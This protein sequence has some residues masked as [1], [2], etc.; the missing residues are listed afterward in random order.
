MKTYRILTIVILPA[1]LLAACNGLVPAD[2]PL[3]AASLS[4]L[5][6][7]VEIKN[8]GQAA[9]VAASDG[10]VLQIQGQVRTGEDGRA[11]LDLS[12]GTII[13]VAPQTLF[14]LESNDESGGS[15]FTR[16][17]MEA[18]RIWVSLHGGSLEVETPSGL[19]SVRGSYLSVWVDPLTN[20]VWVTCLEG[21]CQAENPAAALD[22]I[23]GEGA[24]LYEF[25]LDSNVPPPPPELRYLTQEEIDEF[26]ANNPEAQQVMGAV[27]ATAS[28][29]PFLPSRTPKPTATDK[30][31]EPTKT[32]SP[33]ATPP[34]E[35]FHLLSPLDGASLPVTGELLLQWEA[36]PGAYKYE[37][38]ITA[39]NSQV[40][41]I[42]KI[43]ETS[44]LIYLGS[45]TM[46]GMYSWQVTAL[47]VN[48]LPLCMAGPFTFSKPALL[49]TATATPKPSATPKPTS[50]GAS[51]SEPTF[52]NING[53]TGSSITTCTNHFQADVTDP[54]GIQYVK[55]QY[56]AFDGG[57]NPV[58]N[59]SYQHLS[60]TG[61]ITYAGDLTITMNPNWH[62]AWWFWVIDAKG[63]SAYYPT[64]P[65]YE[66]TYVGGS[67]CY[68]VP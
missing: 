35:C 11:R 45:L 28:A 57:G 19:A 47:D 39:P 62:I 52:A 67:N 31:D 27:I 29:L 24:I 6:G 36:Q 38:A 40:S 2:G 33:T 32:P 48:R 30:P 44:H 18:G 58:Y 1:L 4:E 34:A 51:N 43:G 66:F 23:A 68:G 63:K 8:P 3:W 46:G 49:L 54:D 22:M 65:L 55:V 61:G 5:A 64:S 59:G 41:T 17:V 16:L 7:L 53:P 12:T 60:N 15:L 37:I 14:T 56:K 13:R 10:M 25:N 9:F 20:D 42:L 26:V 21:W 50:T